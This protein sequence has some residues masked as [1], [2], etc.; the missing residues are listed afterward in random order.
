MKKLL[1]CFITIAMLA[2]SLVPVSIAQEP[3]S[4]P[5]IVPVETNTGDMSRV[6]YNNPGLLTDWTEGFL[7]NPYVGDYNGD[8][9]MDIANH[10]GA[11]GSAGVYVAYGSAT[12]H[13]D[14]ILTQGHLVSGKLWSSATSLIFDDDGNWVDTWGIDSGFL[15]RDFVNSFW[16]GEKIEIGKNIIWPKEGDRGEMMY[17]VDYDGD[18]YLDCIKTASD[19]AEYGWA[20]KWD[21]TGHWGDE[22][23]DPQHG[24]VMWAKNIGRSNDEF[25]FEDEAKLVC[26]NN[27]PSTP[28]DVRGNASA[29]FCDYD[30]DGDLDLFLADFI[31]SIFYFEN[32][33][34]KS[35]PC[36]AEGVRTHFETENGSEEYH[37]VE[38]IPVIQA[39]D[40]TQDGLFDIIY[41]DAN[42][43]T[44]LLENTGKFADNGAPIFQNIQR[45]QVPANSL[46]IMGAQIAPHSV[47]FDNDGD[48]DIFVAG[49]PGVFWYVENI[50]PVGGPTDNPSW[51]KPITLKREDGVE[52][53]IISGFNGQGPAEEK[54]GHG[55]VQ[56]PAEEVL[57]YPSFTFADWDGDGDLDLVGNSIWGKIYWLE[58]INKPGE[59]EVEYGFAP[60]QDIEVEDETPIKIAWNWW[61]PEPYELVT[62]WRTKPTAIDL[63]QDGLCD[64]VMMDY[65]GYCA[66]F[67]RLPNGRVTTGQRI[68][69][70]EDGTP[71][72]LTAAQYGGSGRIQF[73]MTDW[74]GD[75][76]LDIVRDDT[77]SIAW[78]ENV[79]SAEDP[80]VYR[81]MV[82]L[83]DRLL[84]AHI[85]SPTIVDWNRD[86]VSD[87]LVGD[88]GGFFY[89]LIN[90]TPQ[91]TDMES[92][93][94][95]E[96]VLVAHWDFEGSSPLA[97]K[98]TA[99]AVSDTLSGDITVAN[100]YATLADGTSAYLS[101]DGTSTD[102]SQSGEMTVVLR[103]R[104][105][106]AS[107][108]VLLNK[109]SSY[110]INL[111]SSANVIA[112][113]AGVDNVNN[114]GIA[115]N[116]WTT[117][118][119]VLRNNAE[120]LLTAEVY[121]NNDEN[122][123]AIDFKPYNR[124]GIG[125]ATIA[126]NSNALN[127][128]GNDNAHIG[129]IDFDDIRIYSAALTPAQLA[130]LSYSSPAVTTEDIEEV[131]AELPERGERYTG[132]SYNDLAKAAAAAEEALISGENLEEA[133]R[134]LNGAYWALVEI[135]PTYAELSALIVAMNDKDAAVYT[136]DSYANLQ[137][138]VSVANAV[139]SGATQEAITD[140]YVG[141]LEA[142]SDLVYN[143]YTVYFD[144]NGGSCSTASQ[145]TTDL[146]ISDFPVAEKDSKYEFKGW[147]TEAEGGVLVT[148]ATEF[149]SD[150][151]IYAHYLFVGEGSGIDGRL[152]VEGA[153]I[154]L[155]S[156]D[157]TVTQGIRFRSTM[158]VDLYNLLDVTER[159]DSADDTGIGF[160]TVV[161]PTE[162][163][164]D[165]ELTKDTV[166][167]YN[168][169]DF[170]AKVVPAAVLYNKTSSTI[171]FN[172][173]MTDVGEYNYNTEYTVVPYITYNDNE[174][175][176]VTLY[177]V[178]YSTSIFK[179]A[180]AA[181]SDSKITE[182]VKEYLLNNILSKVDP[183][184][185]PA[186]EW[187]GIFRP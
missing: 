16:D 148:E 12:S 46:A 116:E 3:E 146:K 149:T 141:L 154:R 6:P 164:G 57:G 145:T 48:E 22:D 140:A 185:Y 84:Y 66:F 130:E 121:V 100:G 27:D 114:E 93:V 2:S 119:L 28:V 108:A 167:S 158:S 123:E 21:S 144:A 134:A 75:G 69:K 157:G 41:S 62:Q 137:S 109:D 45:F 96:D 117:V 10:A 147:Y 97:D 180:R 181:Y 68:F 179:V 98:A 58:N 29:S 86:G 30:G 67:E 156:D 73:E 176:E 50:T 13:E 99:G 1:T 183:D 5:G 23:G 92:S 128:G 162:I 163:L 71:L 77:T 85:A 126:T 59:Y 129:D 170:A 33:G 184:N 112:G 72:Q 47:D 81:P 115:L 26:V 35:E 131:L 187:T 90:K 38:S 31:D 133:Y 25:I 24:W 32:K 169:R 150:T 9:Y 39:F 7:G 55:S 120:G 159:P 74:N 111:G 63:N 135:A 17:L 139:S 110:F 127:I 171:Y 107:E 103:A 4:Y 14:L 186:D 78:Y 80:F 168:G 165:A 172:A 125:T 54:G 122:P 160:G 89:Y 43:G 56:G 40:W 106:N 11:A 87:A 152:A 34:T 166:I 65:Q 124:F 173:V 15:F 94:V 52:Y 51:A 113:A 83:H 175:G 143:T 104:I 79:G 49:E 88:E 101:A 82:N 142:N 70:N 44:A 153:Q 53:R 118:A 60:M 19:W 155:P 18:G 138:A 42:G 178:A 61:T 151:T 132:A 136:T 76:Y 8:G 182:Y 20:A 105:E 177:G 37:S 95:P 91:F 161:L 102:L 36:Y 64:I 174:L